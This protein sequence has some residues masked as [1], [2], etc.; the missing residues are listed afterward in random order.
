MEKIS[1]VIITRNE[2]KVLQR[3][4]DSLKDIDDIV[5]L[6]TGSTDKTLEIAK[7]HGCNVIEV[8]DKFKIKATADDVFN[9]NNKYKY[10]PSFKLGS[11]Y[12]HFSK[13]RNYAMSF[14]KNDW[15]FMPDADEVVSWDFKKVQE[16]IQNEDQLEYRFCYAYNPDGSCALEFSHSKFFRKSKLKWTKWV[17]EI[18][19]PVEGQNPKPPKYVDFIYH[20]HYQLPKESRGNY[21]PGLELSVLENPND[22]RNTY[23]LAREYFYTGNYEKAIKMFIH[24]IKLGKWKPEIGQAWIF[25]GLSHK[26]LK[27]Y[28]HAI[29][30]FKNS[31]EVYFDRRDAFWEL[32]NIYTELKEYDKAIAYCLAGTAVPFK[33][34]G[35][36]N[37]KD[38]YGWKMEDKLAYLYGLVGNEEQ[39]KIHW[40]EALKH[41]PPR[42]ILEGVKHFYKDFPKVSIIVPTIRKAGFDRLVRSIE[43]NTVYPNYEIV[44]EGK[45]NGTAIQKF[46]NGVKRAKGDFIVYMADDC[47]VE[48]G[49]LVQS[50]VYFKENF[51]NKGLV[52]FNDNYWEDRMAHHFFCTKNVKDELGGEIWHSGYNHLGADNELY[53]RLLNKNLIGYC[54]YAKI[55]HHHYSVPSRGLDKGEFDKYAKRIED[56]KAQDRILLKGR[57][58]IFGFKL[59]YLKENEKEL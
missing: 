34:Q 12:F 17:H 40:L 47:E 28:D 9:W 45:D 53:G 59:I 21:L 44:K 49:W 39:S 6:D 20:N 42:Q 58:K 19:T 2:E 50:Y 23:Y 41:N 31:I 3:L 32:T 35:Y 33:V 27:E 37:S 8:G 46:N 54:K 30:C 25:K 26:A 1:A 22:D 5:I 18:H 29:E 10:T 4:L 57:A 56:H 24:A 52:I 11:G 15:C 36:I 38:L 43:A 13:A 14:A 51:R 55:K 16:V 7:A 48:L